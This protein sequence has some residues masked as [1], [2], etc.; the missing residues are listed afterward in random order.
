MIKA[1]QTITKPGAKSRAKPDL[2]KVTLRE[3][4]PEGLIVDSYLTAGNLKDC[5]ELAYKVW[6]HYKERK[7]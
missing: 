6:Q 5:L 7:S 2:L 4:T 1:S 3:V